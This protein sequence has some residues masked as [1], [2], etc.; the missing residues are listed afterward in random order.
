VFTFIPEHCSGSPRNAVRNHPGIAFTFLRIPQQIELRSKSRF[1][2]S[3]KR[4]HFGSCDCL[5]VSGK[6]RYIRSLCAI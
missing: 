4:I 1:A 3:H 6:D 2:T 5:C